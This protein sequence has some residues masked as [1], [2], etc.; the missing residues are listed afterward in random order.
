MTNLT[1]V[2]GNQVR[3]ISAICLLALVKLCMYGLGYLF[4]DSMYNVQ[5]DSHA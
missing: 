2:I 3:H 1:Q 5:L 4:Y